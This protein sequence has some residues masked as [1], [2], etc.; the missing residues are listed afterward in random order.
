MR[1]G[2]GWNDACILNISSRG[3]Q[4]HASRC[5]PKGDSIELWR[6][7]IVITARVVWRSGARAGLQ[8]D[9]CIPVEDIMSLGQSPALRLTAGNPRER[10]VRHRSHAESRIQARTFEFL[11]IAAIAATL[12]SG[13]FLIV[14]DV[15]ARPLAVVQRAFGG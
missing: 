10:R 14:L 9:E 12:S 7:D 11:S 1:T 2:A 8:S 5:V 13:L 6:G 15:L 4:I 3:L